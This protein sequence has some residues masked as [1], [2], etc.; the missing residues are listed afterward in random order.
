M[1]KYIQSSM[2]GYQAR[3]PGYNPALGKESTLFHHIWQVN[4]SES[5]Q[6]PQM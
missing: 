3:G 4:W 5:S 1:E 6:V 2:M